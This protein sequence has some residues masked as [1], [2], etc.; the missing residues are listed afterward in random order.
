LWDWWR[1][2]I[3][4]APGSFE[5]VESVLDIDVGAPWEGF[6]DHGPFPPEF[7]VFADEEIILDLCPTT[8]V[9][10][11]L[12]VVVPALAA[13][14]DAACRHRGCDILPLVSPEDCDE[15]REATVLLEGE[16]PAITGS[17]RGALGALRVGIREAGV[18]PWGRR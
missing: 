18:A 5:F 7:S 11:R 6:G 10:A 1:I 3:E 16:L 12:Q 15:Q 13:L 2:V 4:L 17:G 9:D 8:V 14:P